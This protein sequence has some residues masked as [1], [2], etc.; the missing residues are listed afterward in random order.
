MSYTDKD[1][2][3]KIKFPYDQKRVITFLWVTK[4]MRKSSFC[5]YSWC[6]MNIFY[7][8]KLLVTIYVNNG[9]KYVKFLRC[10]YPRQSIEILT[11][12]FYG[13]GWSRYIFLGVVY[14]TPSVS[15]VFVTAMLFRIS[16][17]KWRIVREHKSDDVCLTNNSYTFRHRN[18][19][20]F[21]NKTNQKLRYHSS[22]CL[23]EDRD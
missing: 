12:E 4:I 7:I 14:K 5:V 6:D 1:R 20:P 17:N 18:L 16:L 2:R 23:F 13:N 21:L 10:R 3:V 19:I 22:I 11:T 9:M 8:I 15:I